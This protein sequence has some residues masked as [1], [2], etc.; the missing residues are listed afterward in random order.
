MN[1]KNTKTGTVACS[2]IKVCLFFII[3]E[4]IYDEV[5]HSWCPDRGSNP[6]PPEYE[7]KL[8]STKP[9]PRHG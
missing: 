9:H 5:Q 3:S 4:I 2:E 1:C 8:L 7:T 6:G